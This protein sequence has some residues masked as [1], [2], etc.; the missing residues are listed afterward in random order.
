MY[1]NYPKADISKSIN[2]QF[3]LGTDVLMAPIV[4]ED[5]DEVYNMIS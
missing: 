3:M 2:T 5:A 1:L 4:T